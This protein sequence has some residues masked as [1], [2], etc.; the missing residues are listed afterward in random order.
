MAVAVIAFAIYDHIQPVINYPE[1]PLF[2]GNQYLKITSFLDGT[3]SKYRVYFPYNTRILVPALAVLMP[4][5]DTILS[6]KALNLLFTL[7]SLV[8]LFFLWRYYNLSPLLML[9]GFFWLLFHWTGIIRLNLFDPVTVDLPLYLFQTLLLLIVIH[10]KYYWL[11][12]LAPLATAQKEPF[13]GL[14]IVLAAFSV[15]Y[16]KKYRKSD[17]VWIGLALF[18]SLGVKLGLNLAFPPLEKGPNS[19][20]LI[21]YNLK[22]AALDPFRII[23]WI[24]AIFVA[25]GGFLILALQGIRQKPIKSDQ[26]LL[27]LFSVLYFL[28][29]IAAGVDM[30]RIVFLGFPFIMTFLLLIL[31]SIRKDV[32]LFQEWEASL[33]QPMKF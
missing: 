30:L 14:M 11:I 17:L 4:F 21:A 12:V 20:I 23:R 25:F 24:T 1:A 26:V 7:A 10:R 13:L 5:E 18:L 16:R 19:F 9:A 6:F 27:G 32:D 22:L 28:F 29:G 31:K 2:D 33:E 8:A 3:E 15:Y